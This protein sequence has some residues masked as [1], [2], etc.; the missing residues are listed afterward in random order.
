VAAEYFK[1]KSMHRHIR[2]KKYS[3]YININNGVLLL[4][5]MVGPLAYSLEVEGVTVIHLSL[6]TAQHNLSIGLIHN[7]VYVGCRVSNGS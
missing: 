2:T 6:L 1:L 4:F 3:S 7:C 5:S